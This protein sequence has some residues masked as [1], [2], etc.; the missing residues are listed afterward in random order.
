M[1]GANGFW[2]GAASVLPVWR[3]RQ[4]PLG[5][6]GGQLLTLVRAAEDSSL[7]SNA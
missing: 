4:F 5:A 2:M 3:D 6:A 1:G 7:S